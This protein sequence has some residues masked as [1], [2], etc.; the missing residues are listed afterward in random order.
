M[1]EFDKKVFCENLTKMRKEKGY[2]KYEMSIQANIHYTYYLSIEN[3]KMIPNF[4]GLISI[5][6]ALNTDIAHLLGKKKY[7]KKEIIKKDVLSN[8]TKVENDDFL[9]RLLNVLISIRLWSE[10]DNEG[11]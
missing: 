1:L 6:N 3:G 9:L 2:N 5:A 10:T 7:S 8:L 4:K 11:L